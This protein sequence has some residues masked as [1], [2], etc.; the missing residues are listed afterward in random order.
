MLNILWALSEYCI[1][2][3]NSDPASCCYC[4]CCWA[5]SEYFVALRASNPAFA[6][7]VAAPAAAAALPLCIDY[8]HKAISEYVIALGAFNPASAAS[9]VAA[10]LTVL[11]FCDTILTG[12]SL[13]S[14]LH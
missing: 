2:L 14:V 3:G 13:G 9:A 7:A 1:A 5:V 8:P 12:Q 11:L 6:A 4:C 10:D